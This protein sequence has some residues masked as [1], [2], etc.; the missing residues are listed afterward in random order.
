M[1]HFSIP[2]HDRYATHKRLGLS[3]V[4][5]GALL[6]TAAMAWAGP[7][8]TSLPTASPVQQLPPVLLV[9]RR[10]AP[11]Q[12]ENARVAA[13]LPRVQLQGKRAPVV[14]TVP[15]PSLGREPAL[16]LAKLPTPLLD[17]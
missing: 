11:A 10:A 4:L 5:A 14:A 2:C 9:A 8:A 6:G 12:A 3:L 16:V 1:K 13:V 15:A 7:G 17:R